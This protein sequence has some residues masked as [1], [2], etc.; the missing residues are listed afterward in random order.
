MEEIV[1]G[2]RFPREDAVVVEDED[3]A[4]HDARVEMLK[5]RNRRLVDVRIQVEK[6]DAQLGVLLHV[7][8]D[9][10]RDVARHELDEALAPLVLENLH[11]LVH[12]DTLVSRGCDEA[13]TF[14][15]VVVELRLGESAECVE[16]DDTP[17][18]RILEQLPESGEAGERCALEHAALDDRP[19]KVLH[20]TEQLVVRQDLADPGYVARQVEVVLPLEVAGEIRELDHQVVQGSSAVGP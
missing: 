18:E 7:L 5:D 12:G 13:L 11:H 15:P 20:H 4:G 16:R 8:R 9:G 6:R 17:R 1:H 19:G 3:S 10:L 14:F 2:F